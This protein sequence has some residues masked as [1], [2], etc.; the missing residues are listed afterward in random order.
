MTKVRKH[1]DENFLVIRYSFRVLMHS[2][3]YPSEKKARINLQIKTY[4]YARGNR[5]HDG[6]A[7]HYSSVWVTSF[8]QRADFAGTAH[9]IAR[10]R[11]LRDA[12][13]RSP[14]LI[15]KSESPE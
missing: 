5:P 11:R 8:Q 1:N 2:R 7:A 14:R 15:A 6:N 12:P 13:S 9:N 10:R 3:R 4:E